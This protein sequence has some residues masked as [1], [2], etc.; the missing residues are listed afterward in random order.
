M[1]GGG[2]SRVSEFVYLVLL[3]GRGRWTGGGASAG[4]IELFVL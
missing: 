2:G 4:V 3:R 1:G